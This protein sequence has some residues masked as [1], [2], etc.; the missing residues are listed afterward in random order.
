LVLD[1]K[2]PLGLDEL[3]VLE[4]FTL[5]HDA[6]NTPQLAPGSDRVTLTPGKNPDSGHAK[7]ALG[8]A[9]PGWRL[10]H[11]FS[12]EKPGFGTPG[13]SWAR[14]ALGRDRVTVSPGRN[15]DSRHEKFS[16]GPARP[17]QRPG[18]PF[19]RE[20]TGFMTHGICL[21]RRSR[22]QPGNRPTWACTG[23]CRP[24]FSPC[25]L[26]PGLCPGEVAPARILVSRLP[27]TFPVNRCH[28][29]TSVFLFPGSD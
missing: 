11:P 12:R 16:L 18:H 13:I 20:N 24:G 19:S 14:L 27:R 6:D 25:N 8:P 22:V 2:D 7:F 23:R 10:G 26:G 15:P 21:V 4:G 17:G 9:R 28:G 29:T 5:C 3:A 1:L